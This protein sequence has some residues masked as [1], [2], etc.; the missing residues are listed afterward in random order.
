MEED[1]Q[2]R[3]GS[4]RHD[5]PTLAVPKFGGLLRTYDEEPS[6]TS[7]GARPQAAGRLTRAEAH[8]LWRDHQGSKGG[9]GLAT[10]PRPLVGATWTILH[11]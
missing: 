8:R 4:G 7:W 5:V 3:W 11:F 10:G 1:I 9:N 6:P 2:C